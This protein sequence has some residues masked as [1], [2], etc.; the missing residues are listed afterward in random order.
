VST[1]PDPVVVVGAGIP[2]GGTAYDGPLVLVGDEPVL[3]YRRPTVSKGLVRGTQTLEQVRVKPPQWYSEQRVELRTGVAA[4]AVEGRELVL[5]TD[6]RVAWS[7][8]VLATG[9]RGRTLP[10]LDPS[11]RVLSLRTAADAARLTD[12]LGRTAGPV[13]VVGAGLVGAE[14]AAG[15]HETGREVVLLE[16]AALPMSRVLPPVLGEVYADLHRSRGVA[17]ETGVEVAKVLDTGDGV[18]VGAA[19]G[20][21][22]EAGLVVVSVGLAPDLALA[23]GAGLA[24][25]PDGVVV[26]QHGRTCVADIWAAG[27]LALRPSSYVDG[28]RR[29]E[30]WQS[31]QDHGTAVGRA[32]AADL[33]GE[34]LPEPFDEVP[35]AWSDQYSLTLQLTGWPTSDDDVVLRGAPSGE[36]GARWVAFFL[37][38]GVLRGAV[39]VGRPRDIRGARVLVGRRARVERARLA[40]PDVPV[41]ETVLEGLEE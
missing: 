25:R 33:A 40:D 20:R 27:D 9:G 34:P 4:V 2:G 17:L 26:D 18:L 39:G 12:V 36:P 14:I 23:T 7:R 37:R 16:S 35:W 29:A 41:L 15:L 31:A 5:D 28:V 6:E 19:D 22:W 30:H 11:P 13:V 3:P 21:T 24:S 8:L 1:V 32:L 10:G 38:E